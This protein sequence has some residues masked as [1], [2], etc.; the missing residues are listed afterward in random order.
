MNFFEEY[1]E[2]LCSCNKPYQYVGGEFLSCNK[3][4]DEAK[5]R[6]VFAFPDKYEIGISNLGVRV[7]YGTVNNRSEFMADR[8]YAPEVDFKDAL[9]NQNNELYALE[10]KRSLKEFDAIG[11]SLQYELAYPT[12]LKMLDMSNIPIKRVDRGEN[13]PLIL[14]GGPCT[15]NPLPMADFID[16]GR[17][18]CR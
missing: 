9:I 15:F 4:F 1:H 2:L 14:S 17:A 5:V 18:S 8:V 7:L 12:V 6:F 11:F 13:I 10:S 3:S 16:I